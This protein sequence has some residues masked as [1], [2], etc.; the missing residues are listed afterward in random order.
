METLYEVYFNIEIW[1]E[2]KTHCGFANRR[3]RL[4]F[5]PIENM[6]IKFR[7]GEL[8]FTHVLWDMTAQV[9]EA[10]SY[11]IAG[12]DQQK[13]LDV[14]HYIDEFRRDHWNIIQ[15]RERKWHHD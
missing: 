13:Y 9:F 12:W 4:P 8:R 11:V 10:T 1:N 2:E 15:P 6:I 5:Q 3:L 7:V 14:N